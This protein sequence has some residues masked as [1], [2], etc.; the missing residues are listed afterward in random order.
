MLWYRSDILV[1]LTGQG[2]QSYIHIT[3]A[4]L[5][6]PVLFVI[7]CNGSSIMLSKTIQ[8]RAAKCFRLDLMAPQYLS[9]QRLTVNG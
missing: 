2:M 3:A 4:Y 6:V 1:N 8:V 7:N 9:H 5:L